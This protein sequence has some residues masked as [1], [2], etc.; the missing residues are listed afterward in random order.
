METLYKKYTLKEAKQII[1]DLV[2]KSINFEDTFKKNF[3][4]NFTKIIQI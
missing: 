3:W 1:R 2:E 4:M